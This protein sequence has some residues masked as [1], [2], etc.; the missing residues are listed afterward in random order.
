[1][2]DLI[3]I[4]LDTLPVSDDKYTKTKI[5]ACGDRIYTNFGDLNVPEDGL[6]CESFT[7]IFI[8]SLL[9]YDNKYYLEVYLENCPCKIVN[10]Q[11]IDCLDDSL[12]ESDENFVNVVLR[13]N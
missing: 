4:A 9:V 13:Q 10:T 1:M 6:E 12:F 7:V 2:E 5:K 3:N 11:M 8:A